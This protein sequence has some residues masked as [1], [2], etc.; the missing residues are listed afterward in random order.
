MDIAHLKEFLVLA[1][2][3]NY[4]EAAERLFI[5]Q[6]SL[7]KHIKGIEAEVKCQLFDRTTRRVSLNK[8]GQIFLPY[9]KKIVETQK[10]YTAE[11]MERNKDLDS[12]L[13]IGAPPALG[14]Y[15]ILEIISK[16]RLEN[17]SCGIKTLE[18]G[19][20]ELKESLRSHECNLAFIRHNLNEKFPNFVMRAY[21]T[22]TIVAIVPTNHPLSSRGVI[23][24]AELKNENF[25]FPRGNFMEQLNTHACVSA[26]FTP[27]VIFTS[28]RAT[29]IIEMIRNGLGVGLLLKGPTFYEAHDNVVVLD[30]EPPVQSCISIC[31][32]KKHPMNKPTQCFLEYAFSNMDS[33]NKI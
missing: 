32:E 16:F 10:E 9:A 17:P 18:A 30:I 8:N 4:L 28:N 7:S 21:T 14:A 20:D 1:E 13:I 31:Y 2:C 22:D 19:S 29:N 11:L 12:E 27:N 15:H 25:L 26:G 6:P 5:S 3:N 23:S 33:I 24:L